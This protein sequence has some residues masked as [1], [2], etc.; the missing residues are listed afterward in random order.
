[1]NKYAFKIKFLGTCACDFSSKLNAEFK[2]S[3]DLDAR[4]SSSMLI[5]NTY[6]VDAGDHIL[7][8]LRIANKN[9]E[10]IT[11]LFITHTHS[12]HFNC[13]NIASIASEKSEP[14]HL[15]IR[16]DA[17]IDDVA[18]VDIIR[19]TPYKKY[20]VGNGLTVTAL[21]ANHDPET[22]PSHFLFERDGKSIFYGCDGAW[23]LC[24]T[25]NFLKGMELSLAVLDCTVG[26]Y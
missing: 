19:M 9:A 21:C 8:S 16:E 18:N 13:E 17:Q 15:Y 26:D 22:A 25:Y 23:L 20:C 7:D 14:L 12:D 5:N 6:L 10:D 2:N 11:D 4:R 24:R 1:M 3:F